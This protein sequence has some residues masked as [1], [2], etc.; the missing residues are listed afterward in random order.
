MLVPSVLG[1]MAGY[2][3]I[4][5]IVAVGLAAIV[6]ASPAL[7]TGFTLAGAAYFIYLGLTLALRAASVPHAYA[8]G[9]AAGSRWLQFA[10]G[11]GMTALNPKGL[12]IFLA[13]MPQFTGTGQAWP[14][15]LQLVMLGSIWIVTCALF[16]LALGAAS[17]TIAQARPR[18]GQLI[19]RGAGGAMVLL[20]LALLVERV[21]ALT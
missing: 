6:A 4:T 1:L 7:L 2:S 8:G 20:G 18:V 9:R 3:I 16:Y 5:A 17:R 13:T 19:S 10:S 12:L 11:V 15:P 21:L 14:L